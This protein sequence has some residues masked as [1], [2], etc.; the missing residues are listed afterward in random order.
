[1]REPALLL[2]ENFA[3]AF[4]LHPGMTLD[5]PTPSGSKTFVIRA[6][7]VDYSDEQGWAMID[8]RWYREYWGDD[9]VDVIKLYLP[10]GSDG[11][12]ATLAEAERVAEEVRRRLAT[13]AEGAAADDALYVITSAALKDEIRHTIDDTFA[14][15]DASQLIAFVVAILGVVG[16][17]LAAVLDRTREIG[18]LRAIGAT[19]RQVLQAIVAE[20]GFL[21]LVS[22]VIGVAVGVPAALVFTRV[23]GVAATGW[24]VPFHFPTLAATRVGLAIV[25]V[26]ALSGL[27]PGRRAS[28]L[29]ITKALAYE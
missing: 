28:R 4:S 7:V 19:R 9:R 22:A 20:A 26:A 18:V 23:I 2:A 17:M 21:G 15:G 25:I 16:T 8:Q 24:D 27:I 14:I 6:V 11:A 1:T 5:L 13:S 12:P 29:K 3:R 10:L